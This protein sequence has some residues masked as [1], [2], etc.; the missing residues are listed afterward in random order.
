MATTVT[1]RSSTAVI[2]AL[3]GVSTASFSMLQSLISPVLPTVQHELHTTQAGVS[4]VLI[5]WLLSASVATP[6]LGRIGD[7]SGKRTALLIVLGA[8]AAGSLV[9][10]LAPSIGC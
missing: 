3:L 9:S 4:W 8:I 5:A 7:M 6:I 10:A 2:F 1:R